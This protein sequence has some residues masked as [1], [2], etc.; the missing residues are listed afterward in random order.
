[1][2]WA[3]LF[4]RYW[5]EIVIVLLIGI[6][7]AG[8]VYLKNEISSLEKNNEVLQSK[9]HEANAYLNTQNAA[10]LANK[11]DYNASMAK[12]PQE[13]QK[14]D[15][16]YITKTVEVVKWRDNNATQSDCNASVAY[17]NDYKF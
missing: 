9:L 1:M 7:I 17:L 8:D 14:I 11:A 10:I 13:M 4:K 3:E 5:A 2:I 12:L 16:K 6:V 15:T